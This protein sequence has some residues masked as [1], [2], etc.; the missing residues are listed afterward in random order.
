MEMLM[1][2][3]VVALSVALPLAFVSCCMLYTFFRQQFYHDDT[4]AV[5]AASGNHCVVDVSTSE[6][7]S[8]SKKILFS[9]DYYRQQR[10]SEQKGLPAKESLGQRL[11]SQSLGAALDSVRQ[12]SARLHHLQQQR[13]AKIERPQERSSH[14]KT[15]DFRP[16]RIQ[17]S[18]VLDPLA[19]PRCSLPLNVHRELT[20]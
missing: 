6:G 1:L 19:L 2:V 7:S 8:Y 12:V 11:D 18:V 20:V 9:D 16:T 5:P 3:L 15:K 17:A 13:S 4:R 14:M 10:L